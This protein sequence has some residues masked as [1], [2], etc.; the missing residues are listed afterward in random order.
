MSE[1]GV[2]YD[3]TLVFLYVKNFFT[4]MAVYKRSMFGGENST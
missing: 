2:A 4:E 1:I 3:K